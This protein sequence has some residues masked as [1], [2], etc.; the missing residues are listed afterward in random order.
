M[1]LRLR[2]RI[3]TLTEAVEVLS[4]DFSMSP[5]AVGAEGHDAF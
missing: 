3:S 4:R 5:M 2:D 1:P